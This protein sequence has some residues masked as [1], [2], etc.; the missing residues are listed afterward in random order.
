MRLDGGRLEL[1][2]DAR[3]AAT[4]Y[5]S[6]PSSTDFPLQPDRRKVHR[7]KHGRTGQSVAVSADGSTVI[8]GAPATSGKVGAAY[9]VEHST[10]G[11][12]AEWYLQQKLTGA[13]E[14]AGGRFGERVALSADGNTA[15]LAVLVTA[16]KTAALLGV[17]PLGGNL[18]SA[19][20]EAHWG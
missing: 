10:E 14:A 8:I 2:I 13:G 16:E 11:F 6:T 7:R 4:R 12:P 9:V 18:D 19:G 17:H 15:L 3:N 1:L 5:G 20:R